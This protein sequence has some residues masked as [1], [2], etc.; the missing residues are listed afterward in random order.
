MAASTFYSS[1]PFTLP[2]PPASTFLL[3]PRTLGPWPTLCQWRRYPSPDSHSGG[4]VPVEQ[5][6][7]LS[8]RC[9]VR[10]NTL[11]I[12]LSH[13]LT[14]VLKGQG[15][16]LCIFCPFSGTSD[17]LGS[18]QECVK[19]TMYIRGLPKKIVFFQWP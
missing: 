13:F 4:C 19:I 12:N 8:S 10:Q 11:K 7:P 14:P 6:I 2:Q 1:L 16:K 15:Q 9:Q 17:T 18:S 5:W 3:F